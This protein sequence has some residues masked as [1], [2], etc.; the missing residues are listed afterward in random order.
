MKKG[1][2]KLGA[3]LLTVAMALAMN[4]TVFAVGMDG[5]AGRIGEF[6]S[7]DTV[8]NQ[9]KNVVIYKEITAY[10]PET[11]EVNAPTITYN[12][13]IGAATVA[14]GT[15]VTDNA[16]RHTSGN[17]QVEVK[18]GVGAPTITG[19]D[20]GVLAITPGNQLNASQY[21]TA[22]RFD[23]TVNFSTVTEWTGAGVYR[24]VI[25]ETTTA[26]TKNSA[27]IEE[28]TTPKS[29][30]LDVYVDGSG[31]IYGYVLFTN[32]TSID[33][34]TSEDTAASTA[35]KIEGFVDDVDD[36]VYSSTDTSTADKYYTFNV[37]LKKVVVNDNYASTNHTQFPFTVT[38]D[39]SSVTAA[40]LPI[41]T[42]GTNATQGALS[43]S[44]IGTGTNATVWNPTIADGATVKYVGIPCG[45]TIDVY[46]TNNVTG[47]TYNSVSTNADT[48]ATDKTINNGDDSNTATID[49]TTALTA[50]TENHTETASKALT[51]TN[52][53]LQISPTGF[54]VRF[55]PYALVLFGGIFLIVLGVVLYNRT[56]RE[57]A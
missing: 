13:T 51:F 2:K 40:V 24:Y 57:E 30:Y 3:V 8:V 29:L 17:V 9:E 36:Y 46:E 22:N 43:A 31:N 39:N 12:Y 5:E 34:S 20:A 18:A 26:T 14:S 42:V 49:C 56:K 47:V 55:A 15:K 7:P 44:A 33:G 54:V 37:E 41:M 28:G 38:L 48:D 11:C 4:S 32:N 53:L 21:G 27:G 50:A 19:T 16:S 52:T 1:F 6:T 25:E 23:L 35:G 10:N 45:T